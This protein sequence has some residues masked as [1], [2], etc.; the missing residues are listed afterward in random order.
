MN[1]KLI[2]QW[3]KEHNIIFAKNFTDALSHMAKEYKKTII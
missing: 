1:Y 2:D 3:L